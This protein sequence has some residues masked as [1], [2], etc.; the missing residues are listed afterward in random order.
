MGVNNNK[1]STNYLRCHIYYVVKDI[2]RLH[3]PFIVVVNNA[4]NANIANNG[5][6]YTS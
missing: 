6:K 2:E 5:A 3:L 1:I 4:N